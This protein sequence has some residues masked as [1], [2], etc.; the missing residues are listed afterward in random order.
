MK[1]RENNKFGQSHKALSL[2][3]ESDSATEENGYLIRE[4]NQ[5]TKY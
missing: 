5:F 2:T 1:P 4:M 3:K